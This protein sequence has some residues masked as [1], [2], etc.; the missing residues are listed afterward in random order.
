MGALQS[1]AS[2]FV[3][4]PP[5][6]DP[7]GRLQFLAQ[8]LQ[9]VEQIIAK[10][11]VPDQVDDAQAQADTRSVRDQLDRAASTLTAAATMVFP[12]TVMRNLFIV[13]W[14]TVSYGS[15]VHAPDWR[16]AV[17]TQGIMTAK[18]LED[19]YMARI[20]TLQAMIQVAESGAMD[21]LFAQKA[22][23]EGTQGLG[24][25]PILV[26]IALILAFALLVAVGYAVYNWTMLSINNAELLKRADKLC[27]DKAG[28]PI[29][30]VQ[31]DCIALLQSIQKGNATAGANDPLN[32]IIKYAAIG[33][34]VYLGLLLL[35]DLLKK[36]LN[37]P[38]AAT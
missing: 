38:A 16:Q 12:S 21:D 30:A 17:L 1:L 22:Q 19:D 9:Y 3:V 8:H 25:I 14:D 33:G 34:A 15:K 5:P 36:L 24:A 31:A 23:V 20:G 18:Q 13:L 4:S 35:P 27:F 7:A 29:P 10:L 11:P 26:A 32:T 2:R 28:N 6:A 37:R